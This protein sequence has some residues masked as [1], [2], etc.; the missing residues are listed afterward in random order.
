M[1]TLWK[2]IEQRS[3][4]VGVIGLGHTGLFLANEFRQQGFPLI[5]YDIDT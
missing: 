4:V 1:R 3:V 2:K 5:G